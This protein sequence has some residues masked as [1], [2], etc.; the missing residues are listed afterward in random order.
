MKNKKCSKCNKIKSIKKFHKKNGRISKTNAYCKKCNSNYCKE[1]YNKNKEKYSAASKAWAKANKEKRTNIF[2]NSHYKQVFG[3]TLED[4]NIMLVSQG[5]ACAICKLPESVKLPS[6]AIK[7]LSIDHCHNTGKIR[8]LLCY[9]H[10]VGIGFF[11][12]NIEYL[13]SAIDYIRKH[14]E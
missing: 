6:G 1:A 3:I 11:D 14:N 9:R 10:N 8:G 13:N 5:G 4:Y 2:R 7:S 12:E